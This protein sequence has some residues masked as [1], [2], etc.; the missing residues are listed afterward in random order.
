M[1]RA[2]DDHIDILSR[3]LERPLE[4][5]FDQWVADRGP[6][7]LAQGVLDGP[8]EAQC[9]ESLQELLQRRKQFNLIVDLP[10]ALSEDFDGWLGS[11]IPGP[12]DPAIDA[13]IELRRCLASE[14]LSLALRYAKGLYAKY[15]WSAAFWSFRSAAQALHSLSSLTTLQDPATAPQAARRLLRRYDRLT[16]ERFELCRLTLFGADTLEEGDFSED[17]LGDTASARLLQSLHRSAS[18]ADSY[19]ARE[20]WRRASW[21]YES[22]LSIRHKALYHPACAAFREALRV[23]YP[24][25]AANRAY[26]LSRAGA[27]SQAAYALEVG[28]DSL[29]YDV[30]QLSSLAEAERQTD[31]AWR[32]GQYEAA[33][34]NPLVRDA[35]TPEGLRRLAALFSIMSD[36]DSK[37]FHGSPPGGEEQAAIARKYLDQIQPAPVDGNR[38]LLAEKRR[39]FLTG[40]SKASAGRNAA[41]SL[42]AFSRALIQPKRQPWVVKGSDVDPKFDADEYSR[43]YSRG[44]YPASSCLPNYPIVQLATTGKGTIA[45]LS[46]CDARQKRRVASLQIAFTTADL[47]ALVYGGGFGKE[48]W[49]AAL[50]NQGHDPLRWETQVQNICFQL[51]ER[52]IR[53]L[54]EW[55]GETHRGCTLICGGLLALLPLHAATWQTPSGSKRFMDELDIAFAPSVS[56]LARARE[57]FSRTRVLDCVAVA[58]PAPTN[59]RPLPCAKMEVDVI[60]MRFMREWGSAYMAAR[61]IEGTDASR[62]F[63]L[64]SLNGTYHQI[65]HIA[66]HAVSD[67]TTFGKTG[68]ILSKDERLTP[69]DIL[70]VASNARL[71][72][73]S[74]CETAVSDETS[75]NE[76][77][78]FPSILLGCG[79]AGAVGS[80]WEVDDVSSALVMIRFYEEWL[81]NGKHPSAALRAAQSWLSSASRSELGEYLS[82]EQLPWYHNRL[83]PTAREELRAAWSGLRAKLPDVGMDERPY[84]SVVFWGAFQSFGV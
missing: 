3:C 59:K 34:R 66:C 48:G 61:V 20:A 23:A 16:F 53:P 51:G 13:L 72:V 45:L 10:E 78:S 42:E 32:L 18:I 29:M 52:L 76:A 35:I 47:H 31:F 83:P 57:C 8:R 77:L 4:E 55:I 71:A 12:R 49:L 11:V 1:R 17:A 82:P 6:L 67:V 68:I 74:C 9:L 65:V 70:R 38:D 79:F 41:T 26:S 19:F 2:L 30:M 54:S 46:F 36:E 37:Q 15:Q 25:L 27:T 81:D 63:V 84:S 22:A 60:A 24:H 14:R 44:A 50:A 7:K 69:S 64:I 21:Y 56:L 5:V 43:G 80:L 28:R 58:D 40:H 75:L 33:E 73:L 62:D 39:E